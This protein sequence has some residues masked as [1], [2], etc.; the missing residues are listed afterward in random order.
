[1]KRNR[2]D[3]VL[4][5]AIVLI[6][7]IV[8]DAYCQTNED[9]EP[10]MVTYRKDCNFIIPHANL[11]SG[12]YFMVHKD[13]VYADGTIVTET[14]NSMWWG[15]IEGIDDH[16]WRNEVYSH[17][18]GDY[19]TDNGL[20]LRYS[21]V[22]YDY[23][24]FYGRLSSEY[25]QLFDVSYHS[26]GVPDLNKLSIRDDEF[27]DN[28]V[29]MHNLR[30]YSLNNDRV[31]YLNPD[32]LQE[33]IEGWYYYLIDRGAVFSKYISYLDYKNGL[34]HI[35]LRNYR[36]IFQH[37]GYILWA[38]GQ[39]F[40]FYDFKPTFDVELRMKDATMPNGQ[41]AK[42]ITYDCRRKYSVGPD[43]Y[44]AIVDTIYQLTPEEARQWSPKPSTISLQVG[45]EK[46]VN[47]P[48]FSASMIEADGQNVI[49]RKEE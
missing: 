28:W 4:R 43:C 24:D 30:K 25:R 40:D 44:W 8:P 7:F 42:I 5:C 11:P 39:L 22:T 21:P 20:K 37:I 45:C 12:R 26:I 15:P 46:L 48:P 47:E 6:L 36:F 23:D 16:G 3:T 41:P 49:W 19:Y 17:A 31:N 18:T 29:E 2:F 33:A 38:E 9:D 13:K 27:E 32:S 14:S 35:T 10:I 34:D 1:M